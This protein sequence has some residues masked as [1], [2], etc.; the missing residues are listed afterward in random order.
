MARRFVPP[1]TMGPAY[2]PS[3]ERRWRVTTLAG[4]LTLNLPFL[5]RADLA[6]PLAASAITVYPALVSL[7][8]MGLDAA[9]A[10]R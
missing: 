4:G 7:P 3:A 10:W 8:V 5:A 6:L 1:T 9:K 2:V